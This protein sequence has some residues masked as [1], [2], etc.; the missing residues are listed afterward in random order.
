[1]H[2]IELLEFGRDDIDSIV[3]NLSSQEIDRLAFGAIQLDA[4]GTILQFNSTEGAIA[5]V[6]PK[7]AIGKN[8]FTELAPCTDTRTFR[9]VFE[10]GVLAGSLQTMIEYTFDANGMVPTKVLVHM[11]SS[12][13]GNTFWI[14]V[15][16]L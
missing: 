1:M 2:E 14:F 16:R 3:P 12:L 6:D 7:T 9:G 4:D 10:A 11:K 13:L 5:S 8:F 15:K